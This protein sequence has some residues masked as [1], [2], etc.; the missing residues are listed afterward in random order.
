MN[1]LSIGM[2]LFVL[3]TLP[4]AAILAGD[5]H[6]K[7]GDPP[8]SHKNTNMDFGDEIDNLLEIENEQ[9]EDVPYPEGNGRVCWHYV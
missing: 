8:L 7:L 2:I 1:S 4:N 5:S 9:Y 3:N 6:S